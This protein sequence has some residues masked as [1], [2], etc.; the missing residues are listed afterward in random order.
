[1]ARFLSPEW[2]ADMATAA[3]ASEDLQRAAAGLDLSVRHVVRGTPNGD[4]AYT[5]RFQEGTVSVAS[6]AA[7]DVEVTSD[8]PTAAA[9]SQGRLSPA[10]AFASGRMKLAGHVG[11]LA[12]NAGLLSA[13]GDVFGSVRTRTEY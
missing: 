12:A 8:Y 5:M 9:V 1:M 7:G 13:L 3:A 11:S 6:D 10:M 4:V 2:L